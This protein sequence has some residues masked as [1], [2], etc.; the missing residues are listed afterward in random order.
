MLVMELWGMDERC[1]SWN[2]GVWM[3]DVGHGTMGCE[4]CA[5]AC[6]QVYFGTSLCSS[7]RHRES[8][9]MNCCGKAAK[10]TS[11]PCCNFK[12]KQGKH[13]NQCPNVVPMIDYSR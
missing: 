4:P 6:M 10:S 9:L 3:R 1:W 7:C 12:L 2:Y 11:S 5:V 13:L 8:R